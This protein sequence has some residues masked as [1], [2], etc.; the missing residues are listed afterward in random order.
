MYDLFVRHLHL[1]LNHQWGNTQHI[2]K[3]AD[4]LGRIEVTK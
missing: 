4:I 3:L 2:Y 1:C